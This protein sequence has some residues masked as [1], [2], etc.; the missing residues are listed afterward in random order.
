MSESAPVI[1]EINELAIAEAKANPNGWVYAIVGEYGPSEA[2]PP[3]AIQGAWKVD[4]N[5]QLTGEFK[6]NPNFDPSFRKHPGWRDL[7]SPTSIPKGI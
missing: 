3:Q 7:V 2:V 5:G 4:E 1:P 6:S